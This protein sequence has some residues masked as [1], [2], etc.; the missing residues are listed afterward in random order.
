[1]SASLVGTRHRQSSQSHKT[2][3]FATIGILALLLAG[4]AFGQAPALLWTTNIG[5]TLF[6]VDADANAYANAG[7]AVIQ[8]KSDGTILRTDSICPRSGIA[9]RDAAGNFY[10]AGLLPGHSYNGSDTAFDPQD[11]GGVVLSNM[12]VYLVKY[13]ATGQL[14]WATNAGPTSVKNNSIGVQDF[15]MDNLGNSVVSFRYNLGSATAYQTTAKFDSSGALGWIS[16]ATIGTGAQVRRLTALSSANFYSLTYIDLGSAFLDRFDASGVGVAITNWA[17]PFAYNTDPPHVVLD[18]VGDMYNMEGYPNPINLTKRTPAG[19]VRWSVNTGTT[20]RGVGIDQYDGVYVAS[21]INELS[22][23]DSDGNLAWTRSLPAKCVSLLVDP[24]GNRFLALSGGMVARLGGE[25]L[26]L[27]AITNALV[28]TKTFAGSNW[29]FSIGATG[30]VPLRYYWLLDDVPLPGKTNATLNLT[31]LSPGQSGNYSVIVSN[32]VGSVTSAPALLTVKGVGIFL[33]SQMLTNGTYNF[34][35]SPTLSI[36][37]VF[38]NGSIFYTL[39]GSAPSFASTTYTGTFAVSSNATV[40]ALGYSADFSQSEEADPVDIVLPP[41][42]TLTT[43]TVGPGSIA[44][45]PP[46][47]IYTNS[48]VVTATATPSAGWTFLYWK[49]DAFGGNAKTSVA[50]DQDKSIQAVF[51]TTLSTTVAGNGRVDPSGGVYPYGSVIRLTGIPDAGN[52]FGVWG[53]AASGSANPLY[54]TVTNPNP[55]VSSLFAPLSAG[56]SALTVLINGPGAIQAN[57]AGSVF[58]T[59]QSVNL[60]AT[61]LAGQ[62]FR[63]WSGDASGTQ[64]PVSVAMTQSRVVTANFT[65]WPVLVANPPGLT[66]QG[67]QMTVLSGPGLIYQIQ[68]SSNLGTWTD[69]GVVTNTSGTTL[70]TDLSA[71]NLPQ[72]FYRGTA[73]P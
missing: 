10:F 61:P 47:G 39:D 71:T 24:S 34:L 42:H 14:L 63:N 1:M 30:S 65:N 17:G 7:G 5:A 29:V 60:T 22:R 56:Q 2:S 33:G 13:S 64:N 54:F 20:Q 58:A 38:P 46:G 69:L 35:T 6:A 11:F 43:S 32:F 31:N 21:E 26:A 25:T 8:L 67:F 19:T 16:T 57:P 3:V 73:W 70:F 4:P 50:M 18:S 59:N 52:Y 37:S 55:T 36:L 28:G 40:R 44:L 53:N 68:G 49:G 15:V 45:N 27:P 9:I 66:P 51:G 48:T 12:P 41:K 72:R 23:Y 62:G